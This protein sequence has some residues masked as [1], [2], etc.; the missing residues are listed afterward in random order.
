MK[1][2]SRLY[3]PCL[4]ASDVILLVVLDM[5]WPFNFAVLRYN[6]LSPTICLIIVQ[7]CHYHLI[8]QFCAFVLS[9]FRSSLTLFPQSD[10]VFLHSTILVSLVAPFNAR[11]NPPSGLSRNTTLSSPQSELFVNYRVASGR[12][13]LSNLHSPN[14]CAYFFITFLA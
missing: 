14:G 3:H 6:G 8:F 9:S 7:A 5:E 11:Y 12:N 1:L 2:G 13:L 4:T 10:R